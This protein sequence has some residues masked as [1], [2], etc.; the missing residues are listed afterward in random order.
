MEYQE[1]HLLR[2]TIGKG[3]Y[4]SDCC[5]FIRS[6]CINE[7]FWSKAISKSI[8]QLVFIVHFFSPVPYIKFG[9][10]QTEANQYRAGTKKIDQ[11][12]FEYCFTL[13]QKSSK[14]I[15]YSCTLNLF[16]KSVLYT[17]YQ[18]FLLHD[19]AGTKFVQSWYKL[20]I[21][22]QTVCT[23][24]YLAFTYSITAIVTIVSN[25]SN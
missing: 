16:W 19:V 6:S 20:S 5:W 4:H 23:R 25:Y 11:R 9:T 3:S 24:T 22:A 13:F 14:L 10:H 15:L 2:K 1:S 7:N 17:L 12:C 8:E 18:L 21:F